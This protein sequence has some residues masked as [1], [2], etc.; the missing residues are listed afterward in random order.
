MTSPH[1]PDQGNPPHDERRSEALRVPRPTVLEDPEQLPP[2]SH[3]LSLY[4]SDEEAALR[5]A[6]FLA[7]AEDP[8]RA[9]YYVSGERLLAYT[10]RHVRARSPRLAQRVRDL[11]GPQTVREGP[12]FRP[13]AEVVRFVREHPEGVSTGGQTITQYWSRETIA[14]HLEYEQWF[15]Q[16]PREGSR[17][18]CPYDLREVPVD[19]A[20][21]VLANLALHHSHIIFST[22]P[23]PASQV[24]QLATSPRLEEMSPTLERSARW[25]LQ[26]GF[27]TVEAGSG[28]LTLAERGESFARALRSFPAERSE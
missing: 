8:S 16:Q 20:P 11:G 7:G 17:F 23:E 18:L 14:G 26:E 5:A 15:Q 4:A 24:L 1:L 27:A 19:L 28:T 13:A 21:R 3:C 9:T 2:G 25:C 12:Y 22:A 6:A 10:R